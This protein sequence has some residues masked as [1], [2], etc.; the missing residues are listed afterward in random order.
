[1]PVLPLRCASASIDHICLST[2]PRRTVVFQLRGS[3]LPLCFIRPRDS[4]PVAF[5]HT[6]DV[7]IAHIICSRTLQLVTGDF[8]PFRTLKKPSVLVGSTPFRVTSKL[9]SHRKQARS[10]LIPCKFLSY[11]FC[12]G[13]RGQP[14]A[15][16]AR[17]D[18]LLRTYSIHG[19][20]VVERYVTFA[21]CDALSQR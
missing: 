19:E 10:R 7:T 14:D 17:L 16:C 15:K 1:M 11:H 12:D 20:N 9:V 3:N 4:L 21:T 6:K 5:K 13:K 8:L 18:W 2:Q